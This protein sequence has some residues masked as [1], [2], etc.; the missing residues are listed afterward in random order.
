MRTRIKTSYAPIPQPEQ[1]GALYQEG[2][3]AAVSDAHNIVARLLNTSE[4]LLACGEMT[5]AEK[6][7]VKAVLNLVSNRVRDLQNYK[8]ST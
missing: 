2:Y 1:K 6:R 4:L 7:T 5:A 3:D 8:R